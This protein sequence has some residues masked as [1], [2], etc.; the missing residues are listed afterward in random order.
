MASLTDSPCG[1]SGLYKIYANVNILA[2]QALFV[3]KFSP[4]S[5]KITQITII[6]NYY[7]MLFQYGKNLP[8]IP[9]KVL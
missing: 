2:T 1:Q 4:Y 7:Q 5:L 9:I 3:M 8:Q 6:L